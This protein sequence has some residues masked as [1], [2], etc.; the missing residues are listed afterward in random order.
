MELVFSWFADAGAWPEHPGSGPAVLDQEVVG[1]LRLLDHVETML[2][3]GRPD[4]SAVR[5]IAVYQRKVEAAGAKRF[6]SASFKLDPWSSTR[7]LLGWRDELVEAGW[8]PGVGI[9]R[10]RLADIAAAEEAGPAMPFGRSDRLR[11]VIDALGERPSLS[12]RSVRL[13]DDRSSLPAG[14]RALLEALERCGTL[15]EQIPEQVFASLEGGRLTLLSADTELAAAE[16]LTAWLAA[17]PEGNEGLVFV[18]G[19][20]SALLDHS[21]AKIGLPRI[22]RSATSPHRALLQLLPLAFALAWEPPDPNRLLDLLLLPITPL[23]R[24]VANKLAKVVAEAPGVGGEGWLAVWTDIESSL[25]KEEGADAKKDA[26]RLAQWRLFVEPGRHDPKIGMPRVVARGI[27][28]RISAWAVG[29]FGDSEDQMFMSLAQVAGD[30][31]SAIDAIEQDMLNRLL[32]ERMIEQAV[33]VGASDP[34]AVAEAAPW[35]SV[36]HPGAVWGEAKMVVWWHF[37]D[38]GETTAA[39]K[40]NRLERDALAD[41]GCPLD[42]PEI[43][44]RR[45]SA[46]W[47]RPQRHSRERVILIR[48]SLAGGVDTAAHPLWHSIVAKRPEALDGVLVRAETVLRDP[49]PTFAGRTLKR[50]PVAPVSPPEPR[51]EWAAPA[52]EIHPREFESASSLGSLLSCPLQW[53]LKYASKLRPGVRQSLPDLDKLVGIVAHRIAQ[54]AFPPGPPPEP[55]EVKDFA[56]KRLDE[57]LPRIAATLLLPGASGEHAAARRS[58]PLALAELAR[59]LRSESLTVVSVE[60]DFS[61]PDTLAPGTGATGR[62]DMRAVTPTGRPVVIDLKWYRS[63]KYV[64]ND[65]E[66]GTSLQTA[67]YARHVSDEDVDVAAGYFMLRQRRFLTDA[68]LNGGAATVVKGPGPKETWDKVL[69]SFKAAMDEIEE[70]KVRAAFEHDGEKP[71]KFSDPYLL[72]P[73]NCGRCDFAGICGGNP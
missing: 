71:E 61:T 6:W 40:W 58:V 20:D 54:E 51:P 1:P 43:E 3:L 5:R 33:G 57:L 17:E 55:D 31:V 23:P 16:A 65:L 52:G 62:I 34:T 48:P 30:L 28:A 22:G 66:R 26:A 24:F 7:E 49:A 63:E 50:L 42:G 73:P 12:L 9:E 45:L 11:A 19:K 68:P 41:A 27:A 32:I 37:A 18:L 38:V 67:I 72:T 47:E 29:R 56:A 69:T 64:R 70:G 53:T 25:A 14:W 60:S 4:I 2:G 46:A 44:L 13:V 35:R 8:R 10:T 21:L 39:A 59:F 15:I 36:P